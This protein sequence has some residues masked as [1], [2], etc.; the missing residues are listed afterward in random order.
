MCCIFV[1][2]LGMWGAF[3][4]PTKG[5]F[6]KTDLPKHC[7]LAGRCCNLP[8]CLRG[9]QG[10]WCGGSGWV[11]GYLGSRVMRHVG[12]HMVADTC[13]RCPKLYW[14]LLSLLRANARGSGPNQRKFTSA[15][16]VLELYLGIH[17]SVLALQLRLDALRAKKL[18]TC[19]TTR[20]GEYKR[21][22]HVAL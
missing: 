22:E 10:C 3:S 9:S 12:R 1:T 8:R 14:W 21:A 19:E 7:C 15:S 5:T 17:E 18:R 20:T 2:H 6:N 11:L 16:V 13:Q 4:Q